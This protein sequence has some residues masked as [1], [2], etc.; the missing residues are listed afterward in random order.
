MEPTGGAREPDYS[1]FAG[2][3][4]EDE[5]GGEVVDTDRLALTHYKLT[6]RETGQLRLTPGEQGQ[7]S[8][9]TSVGSG[10]VRE[11]KY[12]LLPEILR[13]INDLFAGSDLD[14]VHQVNVYQSIRNDML[15]SS[16]LQAEAM[17]NAEADFSNSPTI[18]DELEDTPYRV[19]IGHRAGI[20][21]VLGAKKLALLRDALLADGLYRDLRRAAMDAGGGGD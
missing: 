4:R 13:M 12:G 17:A 2:V 3:I 5:P 8:G 15:T 20:Q 18:A 7:V 10:I 14:E 1:H 19:D 21:V 6:R 9:V 16:R 11:T